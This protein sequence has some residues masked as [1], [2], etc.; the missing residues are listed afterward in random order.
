MSLQRS[1]QKGRKVL[2]SIQTTDLRQVGQFTDLLIVSLRFLSFFR[3]WGD[4]QS[5]I[6]ALLK[7]CCQLHILTMQFFD[8]EDEI[9]DITIIADDIVGACASVLS[10]HLSIDYRFNGLYGAFI[11]FEGSRN[12]RIAIDVDDQYSVY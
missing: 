4:R 2:L 11:P 1:E 5:E 7:L 3:S 10:T 12:L 6:D 9:F 8:L